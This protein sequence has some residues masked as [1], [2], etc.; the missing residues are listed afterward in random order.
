M[1]F[2]KY[3][4]IV[5]DGDILELVDQH[6][7]KKILAQYEKMLMGLAHKFKFQYSGYKKMQDDYY[8]NLAMSD[9]I[10]AF[11]VGYKSY[12]CIK[13]NQFSTFI[14]RCVYNYLSKQTRKERKRFND[15]NQIQEVFYSD[16][17]TGSLSDDDMEWLPEDESD[18]YGDLEDSL[19]GFSLMKD[20]KEYLNK[21]EEK[22][23]QILLMRIE[24]DQTLTVIAT[25]VGY[26]RP[27]VTSIINKHLENFK[28]AIQT[29][30]YLGVDG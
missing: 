20:F 10:I 2:D 4:E 12:D 8:F 14:Y 3:E 9:A 28:S 21:I 27:H 7:T 25:V 23:K 22:H 6:G 26:S 17:I 18:D 19:T 11:L 1:I 5:M 15:G 16:V 30:C 29:K 13:G 24:E